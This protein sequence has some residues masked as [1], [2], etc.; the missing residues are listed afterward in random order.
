MK[1]L[2]SFV[3]ILVLVLSV[4]A[5]AFAD[6]DALCITKNPA[7]KV[8]TAG[9]TAFFTS[10]AAGYN[11]LSWTFV[12][13]DGILCSV[14]DFR[15]RFPHA[16]VDGE[17]T[18]TLMIKNLS[19]EMNGW[20]VFCS[21]FNSGTEVNTTRAN[22]YVNAVHMTVPILSNIAPTVSGSIS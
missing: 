5:L 20:A 7:D 4:G 18:T 6:R 1:K 15:C 13:P 9:D 14:Q 11:A 22:L 10:G 2:I 17:G 19:S 8:R 3:L 12:S 21:F 16:S